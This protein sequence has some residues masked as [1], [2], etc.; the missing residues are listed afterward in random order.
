M[1]IRSDTDFC[2]GS[3][4]RG[5]PLIGKHTIGEKRGLLV[6][7][8]WCAHTRK[9]LSTLLGDESPKT[10][11]LSETGSLTLAKAKEVT[12]MKALSE[13]ERRVDDYEVV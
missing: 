6:C 4:S 3:G 13:S 7:I 5:L 9:I 1:L 10:P 8:S 11:L 2:L 12:A